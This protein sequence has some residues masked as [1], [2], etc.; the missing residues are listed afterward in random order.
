MVKIKSA[1]EIAKAYTDSIGTVAPKYQAGVNATSGWKNAAI[2]GQKIYEEKM[3]D[4]AVLA[5]REKGLQNVSEED[6]K[7]KAATTGAAR[8]ASGMQAGADKRTKN[9]EPYRQVI[10]ATSLPDRTS[11]PVQNVTNRVVPIVKALADA[12]NNK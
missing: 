10:E 8:I 12:K 4:S 7:R 2:G 3:R 9:Y 6:W 5:R 1:S 11:D